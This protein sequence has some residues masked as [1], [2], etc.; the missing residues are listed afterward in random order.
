MS[1]RATWAE[2]LAARVKGVPGWKVTRASD[3]NGYRVVAPDKMV[4]PIHL[5]TSDTNAHKWS[6][7]A[8]EVHGFLRDEQ[9]HQ[10][11]RE[12]ERLR[13]L[14]EDQAANDK[15]TKRALERSRAVA[16]AAGPYA[17][18]EADLLWLLSDH[19][20]PM[21][22]KMWLT[23]AVCA[24]L[25]DVNTHNRPMMPP[26]TRKWERRFTEGRYR[27]TG[28]GIQ[29]ANNLMVDGQHRCQASVNTGTTFESFVFVGL[30]PDVFTV[31]DSGTPRTK[32]QALATEGES[33]PAVK[34]AAARLVWL[35]DHVQ[36]LPWPTIWAG[37]A[38]ETDE[39]NTAFEQDPIGLREAHDAWKRLVKADV[40]IVGSAGVAG[41][42]LIR[43]VNKPEIVDEWL[44]GL[45]SGANLPDGDPRI[46]LA[47]AVALQRDEYG[48]RTRRRRNAMEH[49]YLL[50]SAWDRWVRGESIS[51]FTIRK[52]AEIPRVAIRG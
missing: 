31:I 38:V 21:A 4:I 45:R 41:L 24:T 27:L 18:Y 28:Q 16:A 29:L 33:D 7:R 1:T 46:A 14:L 37:M 10:R 2:E 52:G 13:K 39:M 19:P 8:L 40:T 22:R 44:D 42:Y 35:Y 20:S 43:R 25:L 3:G 26:T 23:P 34:A 17:T 51:H 11:A 9:R 47:R 5:S 32:A 30:D 36:P 12:R 48:R 15:A 6:L 50:L 49:A